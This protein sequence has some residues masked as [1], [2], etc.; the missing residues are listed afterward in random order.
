MGVIREM[1]ARDI[2]GVLSVE[3]ES[4]ST[5]WTK[6]LF[7]DELEN[8]HTIYF[9]YEE[10]GEVVGYGGMWQVVDEGQITNIAVKKDYRGRGIASKILEKLIDKAK[11]NRIVV[12]G[13]EVRESNKNALGLYEKYGFCRVGKRPGYYRNPVED[14]LLMDLNL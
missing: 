1:T 5:P 4:F 11:E 10:E 13:L 12:I 6:R 3:E 8:S 14:A 9:V 2:D 7:Y